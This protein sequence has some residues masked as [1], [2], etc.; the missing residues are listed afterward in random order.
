MLKE[1]KNMASNYTNSLFNDYNNLLIKFEKQEKLLKET[2]ELVKT[3]N[4]TIEFLNDSN[5]QLKQEN[6][7]LKLEILRMKSKNNRDSSNS[8]KPSSTNGYKKVPT[9][10]REPIER[11]LIISRELRIIIILIL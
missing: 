9:N 11:S 5:R 1:K 2:N 8:S 10:N 3:L 6:E 7:E 4:K